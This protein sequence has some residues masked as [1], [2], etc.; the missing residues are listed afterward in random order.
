MGGTRLILTSKPVTSRHLSGLLGLI[1]PIELMLLGLTAMLNS[2]AIPPHPP[3]PT[4]LP[5][6]HSLC[7]LDIST[8]L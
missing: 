4:V 7:W 8:H 5:P 3:H 2:V 1:G 6:A